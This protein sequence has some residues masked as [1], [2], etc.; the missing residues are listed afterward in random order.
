M[1]NDW[2]LRAKCR[3]DDPNKYDLDIIK[4]R[5]SQMAVYAALLCNGCPVAAQCAAMAMRNQEQGV[6][7]GGAP[8]RDKFGTGVTEH[9]KQVMLTGKIPQP[10]PT[11]VHALKTRPSRRNSTARDEERQKLW[12]LQRKMERWESRECEVCHVPVKPATMPKEIWPERIRVHD[13]NWRRH[14]CTECGQRQD[15][16]KEDRAYEEARRKLEEQRAQR[17]EAERLRLQ[18]PALNLEELETAEIVTRWQF[19]TCRWCMT[20]IRPTVLPDHYWPDRTLAAN[21]DTC[22]KCHEENA[23]T[24]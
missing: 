14:V 7:L 24:A 2:K 17:E 23:R 21:A 10:K 3:G 9:L 8:V 1:S 11:Q 22:V 18:A 13:P 6:I 20:L 4:L 16:E 15:R 5:P 12:Q 19:R